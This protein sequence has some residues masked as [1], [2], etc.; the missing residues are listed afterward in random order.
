[1]HLVS[2]SWSTT[3]AA[4]LAGG[5][6]EHRMEPRSGGTCRSDEASN[7]LVAGWFS[8]C[9]GAL[10]WAALLIGFVLQRA[11][12]LICRSVRQGDMNS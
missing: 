1:M 6:N 10:L 5:A 4:V 11:L 2:S 7:P 12:L 9:L 3:P 8:L